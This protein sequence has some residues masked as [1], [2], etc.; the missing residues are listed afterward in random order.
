M[1]ALKSLCTSVDPFRQHDILVAKDFPEEKYILSFR[2]LDIPSDIPL[3]YDWVSP[4][5]AND[6][7]KEDTSQSK[8]ITTYKDT[9]ESDHSQSFVFHLEQDQKKLPIAQVDVESLYGR[10]LLEKWDAKPGDFQ[11]RILVSPN[12]NR[13]KNAFFNLV[14]MLLEFV[15]QHPEVTRIVTRLDEV[16][17]SFSDILIVAGFDRVGKIQLPEYRLNI[18]TCTRNSL[19]DRGIQWY[20]QD[21]H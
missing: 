6:L 16:S 15:Y 3:I 13:Y 4:S 8:L 21:Q 14:P 19:T 1:T 20:F 5:L 7:R 10:N 18:Y 2:I 17:Q 9:L 11:V 12:I